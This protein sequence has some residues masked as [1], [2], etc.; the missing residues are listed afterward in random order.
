MTQSDRVQRLQEMFESMTAESTFVESQEAARGAV[1]DDRDLDA[2]LRAVVTGMRERYGFRTT[3]DDAA[4]A[5]IVRGFYVGLGDAELATSLDITSER[6]ARARVNLHLFRPEDT[7]APFDVGD[8]RDI[9]REGATV[10]EA[11]RALD[12]SES[13]VSRYAGVLRRQ[14]AARRS[15]YRYPGEFETLLGVADG[16]DLAAASLTDRR[17]MDEVV[18]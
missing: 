17:T 11:A 9:L 6:V 3:L 14:A 2:A 4:L 12:E 7:A 8:L 13:T 16:R 1:P 5:V 10:A 18:D 15:G